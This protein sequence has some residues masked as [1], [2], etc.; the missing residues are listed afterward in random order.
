MSALDAHSVMSTQALGS[1]TVR[2]GMLSIL[3]ENA[4]VYEGL[5]ER[6]AAP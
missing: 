1:E 5:R 2:T 6:R 4:R 3:L